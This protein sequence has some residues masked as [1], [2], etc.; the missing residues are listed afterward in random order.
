MHGR[1]GYIYLM[2]LEESI[3]PWKCAYKVGRSVR[4]DDRA[5]QIGI[6]LPYSMTIVHSFWVR[7]AAAYERTVHELLRPWH[8]QGEWF[9]P[10]PQWVN[11]FRSLSQFYLDTGEYPPHEPYVHGRRLNEPQGIPE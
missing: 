10:Q 2:R 4:P 5:R 7:D 8:L 11:W 3:D 9:W 6:V 1:F